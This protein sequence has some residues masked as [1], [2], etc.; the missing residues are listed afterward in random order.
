MTINPPNAA[1]RAFWD[2]PW[3]Y[4]QALLVT[5]TLFLNAWVLQNVALTTEVRAPH[6]PFN[7]YALVIL[8][9]LLFFVTWFWRHTHFVRWFGSVP[10]SICSLAFVG[11]LSLLAGIIPQGGPNW[12]QNITS[13]WPFATMLFLLLANLGITTLLRLFSFRI[14]DWGFICNHAGFWI[15]VAS[16]TFGSS[17]IEKLRMIVAE[18]ESTTQALTMSENEPAQAIAMPF[19][20]HLNSFQRDNYHPRLAYFDLTSSDERPKILGTDFSVGQTFQ[21]GTLKATVVQII[22]SAQRTAAGFVTTTEKLS[23]FALELNISDS[24]NS[25]QN[26]RRWISPGVTGK[27][28]LAYQSNEAMLAL[29]EPSAKLFR[30]NVSII[31][32][33]RSS[34]STFVEVNK[35]IE[36][37]GWKVYQAS[38]EITPDGKKY[39]SIFSVVRDPWLAVVFTGAFMML[40]GTFHLF[41]YGIRKSQL[42]E[43]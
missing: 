16:M 19:E 28:P 43:K 27:Q 33:N 7:L 9:M 26:T 4:P 3:G 6:W 18:G 13:S 24:K 36:V 42:Q 8:W 39:L 23:E 10:M 34:T 25:L 40:I 5:S 30:S 32:P 15:V 17:D 20:I 35:P 11:V 1:Q 31:V 12:I 2:K 21:S 22:P 37:L 38:W 41:W 14:S 29:L